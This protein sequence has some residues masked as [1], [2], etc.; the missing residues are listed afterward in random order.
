[1]TFS[2]YM[3]FLLFQYILG[4]TSIEMR[5]FILFTLLPLC[6][7]DPIKITMVDA[8]PLEGETFDTVTY[9]KDIM[10]LFWNS[11][12]RDDRMLKS[13]A[14]DM[15]ATEKDKWVTSNN[16]TIAEMD[17][18]LQKNNHFCTHFIAFNISN[19]TYP[20]IA[21]SHNNERFKK[22]NGSFEYPV[23]R[24]F[25]YE[26]FERTCS[27]NE[28]HCSD[29]DKKLLARW[30]NMTVKEQLREHIEINYLTQQKVKEFEKWKSAL[31]NNF[32][33]KLKELQEWTDDRDRIANMLLYEI[34]K[35]SDLDVI[36]KELEEIKRIA[37]DK[38]SKQEL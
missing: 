18:G 16:V 7:A 8:L 12:N 25:L 9:G 24:T 17:C 31:R 4:R 6:I 28:I 37:A 22:Y 26:Y 13:S 2:V 32:T 33:L 27:L 20:Y 30:R 15:L 36:N 38:L 5:F 34:K 10:F 23:L 35:E 14:W 19:L 11:S 29:N 3:P 21:Y 1:M